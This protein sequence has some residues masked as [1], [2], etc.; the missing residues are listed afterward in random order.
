[1]LLCNIGFSW[2][3]S[4]KF[5]LY[6]GDKLVCARCCSEKHTLILC[7]N[8]SLNLEGSQ[9]QLVLLLNYYFIL[10]CYV[11]FVLLFAAVKGLKKLFVL[12]YIS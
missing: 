6:F 7:C 10:C 2:R 8:R 1:M 4:V 5:I 3:C 9:D 12:L 11:Q